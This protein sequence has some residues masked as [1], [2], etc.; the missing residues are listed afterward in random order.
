METYK[1]Y[2]T[3][4]D[5]RGAGTDANVFVILYGEDDETGRYSLINV[6]SHDYVT[7]S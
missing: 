5:K 1:I 2:V 4:S 7:T 3:T 6:I